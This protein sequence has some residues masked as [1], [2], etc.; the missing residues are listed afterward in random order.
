MAV[1]LHHLKVNVL[2]GAHQN[3]LDANMLNN[4]VE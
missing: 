4:E 1:S 2:F 3:S